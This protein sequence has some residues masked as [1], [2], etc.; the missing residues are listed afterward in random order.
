MP[1]L[2]DRCRVP[3]FAVA[4]SGGRVIFFGTLGSMMTNAMYLE[5]Y[6]LTDESPALALKGLIK[7]LGLMVTESDGVRESPQ[8]DD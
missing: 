1:P 3:F 6:D 7:L 8:P 4:S 5:P 2:S